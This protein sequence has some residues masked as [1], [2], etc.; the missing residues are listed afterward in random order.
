MICFFVVVVLVGAAAE[1]SEVSTPFV[2]P[3]LGPY[4]KYGVATTSSPGNNMDAP[5]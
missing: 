5:N 3:D 1:F 2:H 4:T